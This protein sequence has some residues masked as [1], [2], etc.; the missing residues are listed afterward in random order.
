MNWVQRYIFYRFV[1]MDMRIYDSRGCFFK[2]AGES[3]QAL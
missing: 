2:K 3:P 1:R